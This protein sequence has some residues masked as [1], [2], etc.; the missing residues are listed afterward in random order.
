MGTVD[1]LILDKY[2]MEEVKTQHRKLTV[3][4]Y[5]Y[6]IAYNKVLHDWMLRAYSRMGLPVNVISLLRQ[7]MRYWKT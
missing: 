7:L 5:D 2:I 4:F 6:K 3:T 1:Q